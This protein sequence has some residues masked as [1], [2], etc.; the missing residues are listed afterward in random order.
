[1]SETILD[2]F[3]LGLISLDTFVGSTA[4]NI[5]NSL[6]VLELVRFCFLMPFH[7]IRTIECIFAI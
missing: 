1:M 3:G 7:R 6:M 2:W 4:R 5:L